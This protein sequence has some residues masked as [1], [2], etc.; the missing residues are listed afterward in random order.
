MMADRS[1]PK[2]GNPKCST[3]T[4]IHEGLTFGSGRLDEFGYWSH[5]CRTCAE[6]F[7]LTIEQTRA[8]IKRDFMIDGMPEAAAQLRVDQQ[9]WLRIPAW[10]F[11]AAEERK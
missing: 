2:C 7:D 9:E 8:R 11:A 6:H 3:S 10:P 4:G 5:P 1:T